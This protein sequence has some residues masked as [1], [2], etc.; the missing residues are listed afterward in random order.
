[1]M[2]KQKMCEIKW[3]LINS[4][5]AG[6][7]VFLGTLADGEITIHGACL[8]LLAGLAVAVSKFKDFWE[9]KKPSYAKC[10]FNFI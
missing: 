4:A 2:S 9:D 6:G 8:S 10:L 5:L 3:N 7:L 1:M